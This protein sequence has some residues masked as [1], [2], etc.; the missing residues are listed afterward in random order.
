M[1]PREGSV[2]CGPSTAVG[3]LGSTKHTVSL[4]LSKYIVIIIHLMSAPDGNSLFCFP[5]GLNVSRDEV[6]SK[7]NNIHTTIAFRDKNSIV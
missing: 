2:F 3:G 1:R 7:F 4:G 6:E 5:E